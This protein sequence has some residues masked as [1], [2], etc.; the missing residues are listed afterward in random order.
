MTSY[1]SLITNN[2]RQSPPNSS[3]LPPIDSDSF[4]SPIVALLIYPPKT[5][6]NTGMQNSAQP[7]LRSFQSFR[8]LKS[9]WSL[10]TCASL[11]ALLCAPT[12]AR[13]IISDATQL[14]NIVIIFT[15]DQ[16]Y[17]DVGVFGAKGFVTPNLDRLASQ[18]RIFS[19]F[20]VV[21][22]VCSASRCGL[23][24]G[25]Y[26]NRLGIHGALGPRSKVGLSTNEMT[27]AE[28]V[29]Q[30]GYA[31]AIF[32]K[33]HL[34]DSP[35]FLPLRHGFD[36]YFG[37]P[38][39]ND[40]WPVIDAEN[41]KRN[42]PDLRMFDN[43]KVVIPNVTHEDQNQLTTWY[44]EHAVKFIDA[45]KDGPFLLYLAHNMPHVP[46]HVSDKFR[47]KSER[48]LYGD[49]IEEID[50][51]VGQ[52][53]DALKRNGLEENTWVIFTS[54][55][56]PWLCY[57]DHAG[58]AFPLREGKGTNWEGGTRE[59]CIMRWPGKIPAGT[60]SKDMLMTIDLFPTIAK[61]IHSDLP[62][63]RID[64]LDVWPIIS[65]KPAK[66][67][68]PHEAY[69]FYYEVNQLQAVVTGDGRWKLQLPH[70]YRTLAGKPGG[71]GGT[72]VP[73]ENRK[74]AKSQLY[75]L[76]NDISETTDVS[77]AHADIIKRLEAEAEKARAE[78]GDALTKRTGAG[79]REPGRIDLSD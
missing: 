19:N 77:S 6:F 62:K 43:D 45:H 79:I 5:I 37:L 10:P 68:N 33:W 27:L 53:M 29:K 26:P 57:G 40:M 34:G 9:L 15:D 69:W 72:P 61:L 11:W 20:H 73:Y 32:G 4:F 50:W 12:V 25:C 54:D 22:P 59:P 65:G 42:Y 58:S 71:H 46:L 16:G 39:S 47:G 60:E 8:F 31:T 7:A 30:R 78:L 13:T 48:G 75:D 41:R 17:A 63:H 35:Q 76:V 24:T 66:S 67:K 70:T 1:Q 51:S 36:E 49:V 23:L 52:V 55:N 3:H 38:Y 44:T 64:G 56:G 74:L 28:L 14:P 2:L 21:Q 18:G